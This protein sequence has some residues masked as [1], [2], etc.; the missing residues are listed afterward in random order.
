V[1]DLHGRLNLVR[2]MN[3][4]HTLPRAELQRLLLS[5]NP[6]WALKVT[7]P[8]DEALTQTCEG[9]QNVVRRHGKRPTHQCH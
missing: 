3:C 1:I 9:L 2:C 4:D 6:T 8:A 7:Q 5:S